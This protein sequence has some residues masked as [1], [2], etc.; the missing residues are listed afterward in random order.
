MDALGVPHIEAQDLDDAAAALGFLHARDRGF[1]LELLRLAGQGRLSELF[2]ART[3]D[4]D[5]RLR[6]LTL[7]VPAAVEALPSAERA[8]LEAYCAGIN[9]GLAH[10]PRAAELKLLKRAPAPWT[11]A[12]VLGVARL[13]AWDLSGDADKEAIRAALAA[14]APPAL[15]PALLAP[16]SAL[17]AGVLGADPAAWPTT[18][19]AASPPEGLPLR[20]LDAAAPAPDRVSRAPRAADPAPANAEDALLAAT[21]RVLDN[22]GSGSNGWALAGSQTHDGRPILAGDPHLALGWPPVFYEAHLLTPGLSVSGATFP[23][24]P[25]VVIGQSTHVAW[26]LTTS[27]ADTQDLY[28][29]QVVDEGHY[30]LDGQ[31]VAFEPWPQTFQIKGEEPRTETY[32]LTHWGP[33]Y[34]PGRE[35]RLLAGQTYAISWPGFSTDPLPVTGVFDALSAA[36][37]GAEAIAAI[38]R[39][40]YPSQNWVFAVDNGDIGWVLGGA[41]PLPQASGLPR[42]G[43]RRDSAPSGPRLDADRPQLLNPPGGVIVA[44]NQ[45]LGADPLRSGTYFSGGWRALRQHAVLGARGGWS[46]AAVRGL[47]TDA[48]SLEAAALLPILRRALGDEAA[49]PADQRAALATLDGWR[50]EMAGDQAA[51]LV[52]TAWRAALHSDVAEGIIAEPG[53]RSRWLAEAMSEQPILDALR[54][55]EDAPLWDDP[56]TPAVERLSDRSRAALARATAALRAEWGRDPQDWRWG[57]AH[58]LRLDHPLASVP[59][60]GR[61]YRSPDLPL[62]G[63]R[64]T[65]AAFNNDAP[66]GVYTTSHGPALRQ[67]VV[68]GGEAGFVL[69]GGNAGQPRHPWARNQLEDYVINRQH[70]AGPDANRLHGLRPAGTLTFEPAPATP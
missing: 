57:E 17:G 25:M 14:V 70:E 15:L 40:P 3:L 23:G 43:A 68:P 54:A 67:V 66:N 22:L 31:P 46:P 36:T 47:Q 20:A 63:A 30:L 52:W 26:T 32:R 56:R 41:L 58:A 39:L 62:G 33:V 34:N 61:P 37:T 51:P 24:L 16:S 50:F 19:P 18:A 7:G 48:V 6:L 65:I 64:H 11:P 59:L 1:Q 27:Y 69:P 42:D 9:A 55:G 12:D 35:D 2:G 28:A 13:Q 44:S 8:R 29:L 45:A 10:S 21:L 49:L 4:A 38:T 5:R 60:I 53:L